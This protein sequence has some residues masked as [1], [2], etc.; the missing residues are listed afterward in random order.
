MLWFWTALWWRDINIYFEEYYHLGYNTL[1]TVESQP[2]F[3]RNLSPPSSGPKI[4]RARNKHESRW[5]AKL[6]WLSLDYMALHPRRLYS[7]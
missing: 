4:S 1:Q 6:C 2:T 7:S 5:Q 3:R